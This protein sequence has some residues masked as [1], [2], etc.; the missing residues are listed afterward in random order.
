MSINQ[1]L[2]SILLIIVLSVFFI[3][4]KNNTNEPFLG[5][6]GNSFSEMTANCGSMNSRSSCRGWQ[7]AAHSGG[8]PYKCYWSTSKG[9]CRTQ[10]EPC[11]TAEALVADQQRA[12]AARQDADRIAQEKI[13]A[14]NDACGDADIKQYDT[15][16]WSYNGDIQGNCEN[17]IDPDIE[18]QDKENA[19]NDA[20]GDAN[21][22]Q[23]HTQNWSYGGV[24][25][26][27]C[28]NYSDP[29]E[30][31]LQ[32]NIKPTKCYACDRDVDDKKKSGCEY[33]PKDRCHRGEN[34]D[35][36]RWLGCPNLKDSEAEDRGPWKYC[37]WDEGECVT[38]DEH[39]WTVTDCDDED[40]PWTDPVCK[41]D[42]AESTIPNYLELINGDTNE[43]TNTVKYIH[44]ESKCQYRGC[45]DPDA[46]NTPIL[47]ADFPENQIT[48]RNYECNI[49]DRTPPTLKFSN[50][51]TQEVVNLYLGEAYDEEEPIAIDKNGVSISSLI[52]KHSDLNTNEE[53][54]YFLNYSLNDADGVASVPPMITR[55]VNIKR[56]EFGTTMISLAGENPMVLNLGDEYIEPVGT[57]VSSDGITLD[58]DN[59]FIGKGGE[60]W[61]EDTS[62][63]GYFFRT[64]TVKA[65]V[66]GEE[67]ELA[68]ATRIIIVR[69]SSDR[70]PPSIIL[71]GDNPLRIQK[72]NTYDE[73]NATASA[74]NNTEDLTEEIAI[75]HDVDTNNVGNYIVEYSVSDKYNNSTTIQRIVE[76]FDNNKELC[77]EDILD[78]D[79]CENITHEIQCN[80]VSALYNDSPFHCSWNYETNLCEQEVP[81][82]TR[83]K[84]QKPPPQRPAAQEYWLQN[85]GQKF[86]SN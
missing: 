44:D 69:D 18:Q 15:P 52:V 11:S 40:E 43:D 79:Y 51:Q 78:N 48:N 76:V 19:K 34:N 85:L 8:S 50:G 33:M 65:V 25:Q 12:E 3:I 73:L 2:S 75:N 57:S 80:K 74:N 23:Y 35:G 58:D 77:G 72:G 41:K 20:C 84:A 56:R 67:K 24:I 70:T 17:Y 32:S 63:P 55:V 38:D 60:D 27:N 83:P 37:I 59:I 1:I 7:D 61:D 53:G 21:I 81:C 13:D 42:I 30:E 6:C 16:Y 5:S 29:A 28:E 62:K 14:K 22:T 10:D 82:G 4:L 64:Y 49:P 45:L 9:K 47:P 54:T 68:K 36:G 46:I 31:S 39:D 86:T 26:G 71:N 66:N